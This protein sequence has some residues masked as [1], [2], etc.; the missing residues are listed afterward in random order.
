MVGVQRLVIV[1]FIQ[2]LLGSVA[3]AHAAQVPLNSPN[4]NPLGNRS[5]DSAL[6]EQQRQIQLEQERLARE[7][8]ARDAKNLV[9]PIVPSRRFPGLI[10]SVLPEF[11]LSLCLVTG[12]PSEPIHE[13]R[14]LSFTLPCIR[15]FFTTFPLF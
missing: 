1:G 2:M 12:F 10:P 6:R 9:A 8:Q 11:F 13:L 5:L 14:Y 15:T 7:Q 4:P 3:V